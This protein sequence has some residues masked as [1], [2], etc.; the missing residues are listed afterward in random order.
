M[1]EM[2]ESGGEHDEKL[3]RGLPLSGEMQILILGLIVAALLLFG[4][5]IADFLS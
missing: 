4:D 5:T 3:F 2:Q 1:H